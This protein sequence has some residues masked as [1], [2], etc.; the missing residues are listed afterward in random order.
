LEYVV[1]AC[2]QRRGRSGGGD[3]RWPQFVVREPFDGLPATSGNGTQI[4]FLA[5]SRACVDGAWA[6]ALAMADAMKA[7]QL[8]AH[9]FYAAYCRDPEGNKLCF[10]FTERRHAASTPT[11]PARSEQR[12]NA[13]SYLIQILLPLSAGTAEDPRSLIEGIVEELTAIFGGATASISSPAEGLWNDGG[14][15]EA[16]SIVT[17]EIMV[18]TLELPGGGNIGLALKPCSTKRNWSCALWR[19]RAFERRLPFLRAALR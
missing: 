10:V 18:E 8:C 1:Q 16:D 6:A 7:H 19:L 11:L 2:L 13:N 4:S 9:D 5:G 15:R 12:K 17:V 3:D 14:E